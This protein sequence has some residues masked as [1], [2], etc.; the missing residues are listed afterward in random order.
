MKA[1]ESED[2][3]GTLAKELGDGEASSWGPTGPDGGPMPHL[4]HTT[5]D[6]AAPYDA[7]NVPCLRNCRYYWTTKVHF[8]HGNY[9]G[10]LG[11]HQPMQESH[12]CLRMPGV[13]IELSG[14]SPV[15]ECENG[16]DPADPQEIRERNH[17]RNQYFAEH[18][19]HRPV[20]ATEE[21]ETLIEETTDCEC[22]GKGICD[23]CVSMDAADG[24][25]LIDTDEEEGEPYDGK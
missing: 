23:W 8:E 17:R 1:R 9:A 16:W 21:A 7:Q 24:G 4:V 10:G 5:R 22:G 12:I 19:D 20:L 3:Q 15:S 6:T 13:F 18:P 25:D 14:D 11:G 2:N